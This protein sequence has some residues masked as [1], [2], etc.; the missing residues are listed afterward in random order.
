LRGTNEDGERRHLVS[1][2][3]QAPCSRGSGGD[4]PCAAIGHFARSEPT[5]KPARSMDRFLLS[6]GE[7]MKRHPPILLLAVA[8]L[9][10]F[11]TVVLAQ[12]DYAIG[13]SV[14]AGGGGFS[15]GGA[16]DLQGT[17]G[18]PVTGDSSQGDYSVS[19]GFWGWVQSFFD[20]YLPLVRRNNP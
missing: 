7:D 13:R 17:V 16:Y 8:T 20:V 15:V 12:G 14:I 5:V 2:D 6:P 9:A 19:S 11:T 10:V 18:Q 3:Y 1:I 4:D